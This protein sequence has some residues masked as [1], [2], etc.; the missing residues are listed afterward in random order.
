MNIFHASWAGNEPLWRVFWLY[1]WLLGSFL[2]FIA[3]IFAYFL[4]AP[5]LIALFP[6]SV[7]VLVSMWRCA[8]NTSWRGWGYIVRI[9]VVFCASLVAALVI[10]AFRESLKQ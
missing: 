10:S 9:N 7:W 3:G 2:G 6:W 8:F 1:Y 5:A 4:P